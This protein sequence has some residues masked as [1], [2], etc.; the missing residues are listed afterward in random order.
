MA[1]VADLSGNYAGFQTA[2]D[3]PLSR[4]NRKLGASPY[5]ATVPLYTG[6]TVLDLTTQQVWVAAGTTS[7]DWVPVT[8]VV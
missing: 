7:T 5:G 4:V 1:I 2:P 8:K 6:E 3:K